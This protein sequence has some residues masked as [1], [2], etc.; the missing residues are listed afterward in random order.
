MS[1]KCCFFSSLLIFR[2]IYIGLDLIFSNIYMQVQSFFIAILIRIMRK[3][4]F[5]LLR[6]INIFFPFLNNK[7]IKINFQRPLVLSLFIKPLHDN[8][9]VDEKR[10]CDIF[11]DKN[12]YPFVSRNRDPSIF[13][14]QVG[15]S[16]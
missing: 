7:K 2:S 16:I 13:K 8:A 9:M 12:D 1:P 10:K 3:F 11:T 14:F 15:H 4:L 5:T 6:N